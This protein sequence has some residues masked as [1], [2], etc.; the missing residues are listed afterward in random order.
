MILCRKMA[1]RNRRPFVLS[2]VVAALCS[3]T[4]LRAGAPLEFPGPSPGV[5]VGRA[6]EDELV[7]ENSVIRCDW[8]VSKGRLKPKSVTNRLGGDR[9][10]LTETD[11]IKIALDSGIVRASDLE[12]VRRPRV[13]SLRPNNRSPRLAEQ[14]SGK[15]ISAVLAASDENPTGPLTPGLQIE[16]RAMARIMSA[17]KSS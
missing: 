10:E 2:V 1:R 7:L 5:A 12:I 16:W 13:E 17:S 3:V 11:C 14:S 4:A 9:I 8:T 15:Q 6:H